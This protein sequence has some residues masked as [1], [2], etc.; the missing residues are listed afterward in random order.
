MVPYRDSMATPTLSQRAL[1]GWRGTT[2]CPPTFILAGVVGVVQV[3]ATYAASH[4]Q[5]TRRSFDALAVLLLLVGPLS[6]A[7]MRRYPVAVLLVAFGATLL[8]SVIGY[9]RGP[10]F[11]SLIIAFVNSVMTGHRVVA[12]STIAVGW[13]SFLWL[14]PAFGRDSWPGA[15]AVVG[16]AAWLLCLATVSEVVKTRREGAVARA[17]A[18]REEA[19]RLAGEERLRVAR[20]L[21]DVLAHNISLINVQ[22]GVALHLMDERPEQ[23]RTALTAIRDASKEALGELRS[24]L[25]ILRGVDDAPPRIPNGLAGIDDLVAHAS[26]TGLRVNVDIEG[27]KR[28]LP[29]GVDLAAFRIVQEAITNVVRHAAATTATIH[30]VYGESDLVIEVV[31]DGRGVP[32]APARDGANGIMGMRERAAAVGGELVTGA[33]PGRGF[34]V[35]AWLPVVDSR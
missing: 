35:R 12:W 34:R 8:Y 2:R 22:A 21:H 30:V 26:A 13:A 3:G 14:A 20:E 33:A 4:G 17:Q 5:S 23:A 10:I 1:R 6:L 7:F 25:D 11:I 28:A 32:S 31:D 19:E 24:V 16:L 15:A 27:T 9:P 29:A 18:R